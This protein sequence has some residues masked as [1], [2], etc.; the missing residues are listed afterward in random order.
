MTRTAVAC[1]RW[2]DEF[3]SVP[4]VRMGEC[5]ECGLPIAIHRS[6]DLVLGDHPDVKAVCNACAAAQI[7]PNTKIGSAPTASPSFRMKLPPINEEEL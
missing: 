6:T 5:A 1:R 7:G 3:A 4:N 2:E